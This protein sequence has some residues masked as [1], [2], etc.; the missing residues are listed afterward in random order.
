MGDPPIRSA[1]EEL[2]GLLQEFLMFQSE[3]KVLTPSALKGVRLS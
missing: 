3:A 2:V 1:M